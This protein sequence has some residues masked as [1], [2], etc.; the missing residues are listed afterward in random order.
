MHRC[1]IGVTLIQGEWGYISGKPHNFLA[2]WATPCSIPSSYYL[3]TSKS[4]F[5]VSNVSRARSPTT[6][7]FPEFWKFIF[8]QF[9]FFFFEKNL[10]FY[11]FA[12]SFLYLAL[13][14]FSICHLSHPISSRYPLCLRLN[15]DSCRAVFITVVIQRF[16]R[17][18]S[19]GVYV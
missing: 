16:Q 17:F 2:A 8:L 6:M 10:Y 4:W 19:I 5:C 9:F 18:I 11:N 7:E 12:L 3:L 13:F 14:S 15:I 1:N